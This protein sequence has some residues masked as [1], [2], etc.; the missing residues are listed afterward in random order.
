MSTQ[1]IPEDPLSVEGQYSGIVKWINTPSGMNLDLENLRDHLNDRVFKED[2][3]DKI[4]DSTEIPEI[5]Q[6]NGEIIRKT[7]VS[8]AKI[9]TSTPGELI[10]ARVEM[11]NSGTVSYR[12]NQ[13]LT[14]NAS[15]AQLLIFEHGGL[16][17]CV[18]VAPRDVAQ[19]V[20]DMLR[21]KYSQIGDL[22]N[23]TRLTDASL[24]DIRERLDANLIDS[25]LSEF[26][27]EDLTN[28]EYSGSGFED[29]VDF[30]RIE[31]KGVTQNYMFQTDE[32]VAGEHKTIRIANDGLVRI[33]NNT[34]LE[35]YVRL[36]TDH[37]LPRLHRDSTGEA[38]LD[39]FANDNHPIFVEEAEAHG[40]S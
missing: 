36:L 32:L 6:E 25:I 5:F 38:S 16:F 39:T 27:E 15:S 19:A 1:V 3:S 21:Q 13:I 18:V 26:P 24:Q 30:E 37:I 11:D 33:Y 17:Y 28:V 23:E 4:D 8:G 31:S 34:R 7:S 20:A 9:V 35:T 14:M 10:W 22:I 40:D 12:G 29:N 2:I